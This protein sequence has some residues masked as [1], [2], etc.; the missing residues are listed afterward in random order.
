MLRAYMPDKFKTPG[1][2]VSIN[3]GNSPNVGVVM[4]AKEIEELV[5]LRQEALNA[6]A[7]PGIRDAPNGAFNDSGNS[8]AGVQ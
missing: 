5:R 2:K 1:A 4:G 8:S 6:M 3:S 7:L